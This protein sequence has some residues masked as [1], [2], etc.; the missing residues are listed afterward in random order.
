METNT[1]YRAR[2]LERGACERSPR[3]SPVPHSC[4]SDEELLSVLFSDRA[5][6]I[7][8]DGSEETVSSLL[9]LLDPA[10]PDEWCERICGHPHISFSNGAIFAAAFELARRCIRPHGVRIRAASDVFPLICHHG[11]ARQERFLSLTLS[12]AHE[13]IALRVVSA[14]T[15]SQTMVH[16]REVFAPAIA[17]YASSMIVAHNHP[18]GDLMPSS[19]DRETTR[20]LVE[21][22]KLLGI[23]V[24]D[25]LIFSVNGY[26]S[27]AEEGA[28]G[29]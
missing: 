27:L 26:R 9:T 5:A 23:P 25:H 22:G 4:R 12:G 21:S 11:L 24:I 1:H 16:P 28:L 2:S 3:C 29:A 10:D 7:R 19:A 14:G 15:V 13:L 6:G 20:R 8:V 18:S 17:D